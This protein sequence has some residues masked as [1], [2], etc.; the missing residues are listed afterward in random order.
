MKKLYYSFTSKELENIS[1]EELSKYFQNHFKDVYKIDFQKTIKYI[2]ENIIALTEDQID[3]LFQEENFLQIIDYMINEYKFLPNR[4]VPIALDIVL[5]MKVSNPQKTLFILKKYYSQCKGISHTYHLLFL[6][7]EN[8]KDPSKEYIT[9]LEHYLFNYFEKL[10]INQINRIFDSRN[11]VNKEVLQR[12][13]YKLLNLN[14]IHILIKLYIL[15]FSLMKEKQTE[16]KQHIDSFENLFQVKLTTPEKNFLYFMRN[17]ILDNYIKFPFLNKNKNKKI[18]IAICI[19]GQLR[20]FKKAFKSWQESLKLY[21]VDYYIFISTWKD[22]GYKKIVGRHLYR[23]F[24]LEISEEL[25]IVWEELGEVRF[26]DIFNNLIKLIGKQ[27]YISKEELSIFYETPLENI[28]IHDEKEL[29]EDITNPEKMYLKIEDSY[30]LAKSSKMNFDLFI[31]IRPDKYLEPFKNGINWKELKEKCENGI[32]FSDFSPMFRMHFGPVIGDQIIIANEENA[33]I[34]F[35][36][37]SNFK[38][39]QRIGGMVGM[40]DHFRGHSQLTNLTLIHGLKVDKIPG[41][42]LTDRYLLDAEKPSCKEVLTALEE[43]YK[44]NN[45]H[46]IKKMIDILQEVQRQENL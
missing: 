42:V 33:N 1:S 9:L 28:I 8:P 18:K 7:A 39:I 10:T 2:N 30:N 36:S 24:P 23:H 43:D 5:R 32:V 26:K 4:D 44:Q 20:G 15:S 31:R 41:L 29:T 37:Y 34:L 45:L 19:S 22:I 6:S 38:L 14:N 12:I 21:D 3:K 17:K 11:E 16:I 46:Y 27:Q 35:R 40:P 13:Y 25:M